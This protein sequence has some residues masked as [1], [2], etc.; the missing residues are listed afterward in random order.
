VFFQKTS[1][2]PPSIEEAVN[3]GLVQSTIPAAKRCFMIAL[4][5][6]DR[7]VYVPEGRMMVARLRKAY[8]AIAAVSR[9]TIIR[10]SGTEDNRRL[11]V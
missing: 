6:R 4:S 7:A 2:S 5:R 10:P 11:A 8:V 3:K 1:F 9:A